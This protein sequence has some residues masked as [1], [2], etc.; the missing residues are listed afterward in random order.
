MP[1]RRQAKGERPT[2]QPKVIPKQNMTLDS[3]KR[4]RAK[5]TP[6]AYAHSKARGVSCPAGHPT[7]TQPSLPLPLSSPP[8]PLQSPSLPSPSS[9][10]PQTLRRYRTVAESFYITPITDRLQTTRTYYDVSRSA[11]D[12]IGSASAQTRS[13]P[14]FTFCPTAALTNRMKGYRKHGADVTAVVAGD[15]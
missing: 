6:P 10:L 11:T 9:P 8:C 2:S 3:E 15:H 14:L 13:A 4:L 5:W 12:L 1:Q 7:L